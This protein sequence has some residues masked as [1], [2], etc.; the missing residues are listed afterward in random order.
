MINFTSEVKGF[1]LKNKLKYK[2]GLR[3]IAHKEGKSI[4]ELNYIFTDDESLLEI[5]K[6]Y[7]NHDTYTD[8]ITFDNSE[9]G[10]KEIE[11]DIF[12]SID[13][14]NENAEKFKN[15]FEEELNRVICHGLLHLCGYKDKTDAE[16][17]QMREKEN[18]AML[19]LV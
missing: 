14:I 15:S 11:G 17:H 10:E 2:R 8:I 4:E 7:L 3:E 19:F 6:A 12:I 9:I 16:K 18:Q 1:Q 5:N 13:R